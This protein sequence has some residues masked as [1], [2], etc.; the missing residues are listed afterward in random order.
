MFIMSLIIL[1]RNH[2]ITFDFKCLIFIST[3]FPRYIQIQISIVFQNNKR[4]K[5][6]ATIRLIQQSKVYKIVLNSRDKSFVSNKVEKRKIISMPLE[7][8]IAKFMIYCRFKAK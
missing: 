5:F 3:N 4:K 8:T 2:Q 7:L 6:N 1:S